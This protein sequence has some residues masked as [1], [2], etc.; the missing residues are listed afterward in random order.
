MAH[1]DRC[2]ACGGSFGTRGFG[3]GIC[4]SCAEQQRDIASMRERRRGKPMPSVELLDELEAKHE[5]GELADSLVYVQ[6][7]DDSLVP[8]ELVRKVGERVIL[9]VGEGGV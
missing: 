1:V 4:Q 8:L 3:D 6:L 7:P 9:Y 2:T 5:R